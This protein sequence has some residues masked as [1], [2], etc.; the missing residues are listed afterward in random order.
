MPNALAFIGGGLLEGVGKGLVLDGKQKRERALQKIE[1]DRALELEDVK[2][3]NRRQLQTE[4]R[5]DRQTNAFPNRKPSTKAGRPKTQ[6]FTAS[7]ASLA[8]WP[9]NKPFRRSN[10]CW[11]CRFR[12][13]SPRATESLRSLTT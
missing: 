5:A 12:S 4:D 6:A 13:C 11:M 7:V 1:Q 8:M 3:E 9:K 2:Q 10:P